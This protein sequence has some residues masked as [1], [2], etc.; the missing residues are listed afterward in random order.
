MKG[1][2]LIALALVLPVSGAAAD[3]AR[4][5]VLDLIPVDIGVTETSLLSTRFRQEFD[6]MERFDMVSREDLYAQIEGKGFA[7]A[8]CDDACLD[9][10]GQGLGLRWIVSGTIRLE[11]DRV[12]IEAQLYDIKRKYAFSRITRKAKYDIERLEKREMKHLAEQLVP[13]EE[14]GGTSWWLVVLGGAGAAVWFFSQGG[15]DGIAE[16]DAQSQDPREPL[17]GTADI[18]GTFSGE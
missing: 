2:V 8:S 11:N 15:D 6:E 7:V 13:P 5:A 10:L 4:L 9:A 16:V 1:W 14:R 3:K 18:I 17:T 12:R